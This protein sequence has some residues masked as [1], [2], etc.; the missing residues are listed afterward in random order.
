MPTTTS[1]PT[2][3]TST[4]AVGPICMAAPSGEARAAM[5]VPA[6]R[7]LQSLRGGAGGRPLAPLSE[8]GREHVVQISEVEW[9]RN[10]TEGAVPQGLGRHRDLLAGRDHDDGDRLGLLFVF[11]Y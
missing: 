7:G 10:I 1:R 11:L 5:G 6:G 2:R 8:D 3:R 4:V 9:F